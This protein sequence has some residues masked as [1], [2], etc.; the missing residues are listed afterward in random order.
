M[1]F[2]LSQTWTTPVL[3]SLLKSRGESL[4]IAGF[5]VGQVALTFCHLSPWTCP[6]K[7]VLGIPC[8]GCGLSRACVCL[9]HG[10]W[11]AAM[12]AHAFAPLLVLAVG[13]IGITALLPARARQGVIA[14]VEGVERRTGLAA[15]LLSALMIYW[16]F[17][18]GGVV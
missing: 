9:L 4:A 3:S 17:R 5:A 10:Q 16:C 1:P 11:G 7:A 2:N 15:W 14:W 6:I 8:P 18:L 12:Q 13:L